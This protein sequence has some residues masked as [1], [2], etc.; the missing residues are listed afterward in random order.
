MGC[1]V[2][3]SKVPGSLEQLGDCAIIVDST[4]EEKIAEAVKKLYDNPALRESLIT[5]GRMHSSKW[6]G[7]MYINEIYKIFDSFEKYRRCWSSEKKYEHL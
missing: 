2:I 1:P 3:A 5:K 4:D 7:I 6:T